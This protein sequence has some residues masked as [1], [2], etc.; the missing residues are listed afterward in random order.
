MLSPQMGSGLGVG[1]GVG[2]GSGSAVGLGVGAGVGLGVGVGVGVGVAVGL[3]VGVGFTSTISLI[4]RVTVSFP[5][6]ILTSR[7]PLPHW[8]ASFPTSALNS[9]V[10]LS[11]VATNVKV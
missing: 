7:L 5:V 4:G 11:S 1:V 9:T 6:A 3:G 10:G 8:A 2:V